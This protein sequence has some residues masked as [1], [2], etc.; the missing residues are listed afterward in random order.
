MGR[1]RK[2]VTHGYTDGSTIAVCAAH[3]SRVPSYSDGGASYAGISHGAHSG[4]CEI[5]CA[6]EMAAARAQGCNS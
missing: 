1:G 5:C 2:V 6:A 4:D 3:D